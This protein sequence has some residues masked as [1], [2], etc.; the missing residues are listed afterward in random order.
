MFWSG[1]SSL[2]GLVKSKKAI[3]ENENYF[4]FM[5]DQLVLSRSDVRSLL[6]EREPKEGQEIISTH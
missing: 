4:D 5:Q 3:I 6:P 1:W 2:G